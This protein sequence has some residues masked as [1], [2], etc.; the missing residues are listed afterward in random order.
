MK[1]LAEIS[2]ELN[3]PESF[4]VKGRNIRTQLK[5]KVKRLLKNHPI[6]LKDASPDDYTL[7][8]QPDHE[9]DRKLIEYILEINGET[10]KSKFHRDLVAISK[11]RYNFYYQTGEIDQQAQALFL[12]LGDKDK[13]ILRDLFNSLHNFQ[14]SNCFTKLLTLKENPISNAAAYSNKRAET[15]R[16]EIL[17]N[18]VPIV[19]EWDGSLRNYKGKKIDFLQMAFHILSVSNDCRDAM[20]IEL[21]NSLSYRFGTGITEQ[22]ALDFYENLGGETQFGQIDKMLIREQ[23]TRVSREVFRPRLNVH[24]FTHKSFGGMPDMDNAW[25]FMEGFHGLAHFFDEVYRFGVLKT[26][27]LFQNQ[28]VFLSEIDMFMYMQ[29]PNSPK[30][31]SRR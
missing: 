23:C 30:F 31:K 29:N 16:E 7:R 9:I 12:E 2:E 27:G 19:K 13:Q 6:R 15:V 22:Q 17:L 10:N 25:V 1:K 4:L 18:Y 20:G 14:T 11:L 5:T 26:T 3:G 24:H 8:L 21:R 28:S